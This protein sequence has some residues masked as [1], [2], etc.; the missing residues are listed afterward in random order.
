MPFSYLIITNIRYGWIVSQ[1][2]STGRKKK[3]RPGCKAARFLFSKYVFWYALHLMTNVIVT[4]WNDWKLVLI[5]CRSDC[6][7]TNV[8]WGVQNSIQ[9]K[10]N[11]ICTSIL[12]KTCHNTNIPGYALVCA[13]LR[14]VAT[15]HQRKCVRTRNIE[16]IL[17]DTQNCTVTHFNT[18]YHNVYHCLFHGSHCNIHLST[19]AS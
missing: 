15:L 7:M 17:C 12:Y 5:D 2:P 19:H 16:Q 3:S 18:Q 4:K 14:M 8:W 9:H 11:R 13:E 6:R 10:H 1:D